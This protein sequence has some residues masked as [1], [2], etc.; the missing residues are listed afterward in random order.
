[1]NLRKIII[2]SILSTDLS[3]L[4]ETLNELEKVGFE[5]VH[6]DIMDGKFVQATALNN[7][8]LEKICNSKRKIKFSFHLMTEDINY[9]PKG[10]E[11]DQVFIHIESP[12]NKFLVNASSNFGIAINPESDVPHTNRDILLMSV[13][14]GKG[15]QAFISD[16]I[17]K[18]K[19]AKK[20]N[21]SCKITV[22]GGIT[23]ATAKQCLDAGADYLV[24]GSY[25]FSGNSIKER[26]EEIAKKIIDK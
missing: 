4:D 25:L 24:I 8:E 10:C 2:P 22:D 18:I 15:G 19:L 16:T 21:P 23:D 17:D 14:P 5:K 9:I 7:G 11:G 1:M 12:A 3:K 6:I 13:K 26:L 20:I